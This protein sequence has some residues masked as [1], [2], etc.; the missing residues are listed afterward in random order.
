MVNQLITVNAI[1]ILCVNE[2]WLSP[3]ISDSLIAIPGFKIF[4]RDRD[5]AGGGVLLYVREHIDATARQDL[6][7][8]GITETCWVEIKLPKRPS[9]LLCS[10]YR[11]PSANV[12]YYE[13]LLDSLSCAFAEE[14]E[15]ILLGDL[16]FNYKLDETL[17]K[18]PVHYIEQLYG[19]KQLITDPTRVTLTT[20]TT[21]DVILTSM[22][23]NHVR[24]GVNKVTLS[25]HYMIFTELN[26]PKILKEHKILRFRDFKNF[27][28][29]DFIT[30]LRDSSTIQSVYNIDDLENAWATWKNEVL[31]IFNK[32]APITERRLRDRRNPW[33]ND[34]IVKLTYKR[35]F[36]HEAATDATDNKDTNLWSLYKITRNRVTT[37]IRNAK[38]N[39]F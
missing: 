19:M 38:Q 6:S 1:D 8:N 16:N 32:H 22:S 31:R 30:D 28:E 5:T 17:S 21:I 36:L 10:A 20:S 24:S 26:F 29:N 39:Y 7:N 23:N 12:E 27:N 15:V 13:A 37:V 2:T 14:K 4:R 33:V 34:D 9:F 35:D 18:N 11:P 3:D 25:D